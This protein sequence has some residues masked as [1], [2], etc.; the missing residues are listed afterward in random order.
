MNHFSKSCAYTDLLC[1]RRRGA[2]SAVLERRAGRVGI[3]ERISVSDEDAA[4]KIERPI[5]HYHS[6]HTEK[7]ENMDSFEREDT[8]E[9]L[10]SELWHICELHALLP[11]RLLV[12]G[13]GN[14]RLTPDALGPMAAKEIEATMHLSADAPE[15]FSALECIEIAVNRPGVLADTGIETSV[16]V[17]ALCHTLKPELVILIDALCTAE[18][19]RLGSTFQLSDTG[20][21][22]GSGV[23]NP[24]K[25][26]SK[27]TLGCEV[28]TI[29]IPTVMDAGILS[30]RVPTERMLVTP[31][32]IN[33]I[34]DSGAKIIADAINRAF[35]IIH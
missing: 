15:L 7:I 23:G 22:P 26:I 17:S 32:Y 30:K 27:R 4:R 35:G 28:I 13:L 16:T 29:G 20:I 21:F 31:R 19:E 18:E 6:L 3:W 2:E 1:E 9:E 14:E 25:E 12:V 11:K 33:P 24:R 5:G 34:I 8:A 10:A